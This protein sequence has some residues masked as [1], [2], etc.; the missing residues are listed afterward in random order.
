[1]PLV[2]GKGF[3]LAIHGMCPYLRK[4]KDKQEVYCECAKFKFPDSVARREII[5]AYCAH[6]TDFNN[7]A[8]K[9]VMDRY[10]YER[11]F[12]CEANN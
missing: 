5:Y 8:F 9:Q 2:D 11:K 10:Y 3:I 12:D 7:C 4:M 6:P 1:M